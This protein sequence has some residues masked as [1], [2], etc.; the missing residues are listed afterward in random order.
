MANVGGAMHGHPMG[1]LSGGKAMRQAI[2][3]QF[4]NPEYIKAIEK[5]G[6]K[7]FSPDLAYRI[8]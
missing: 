4:D 3:K 5:W 8:F 7:E 6:H 2:D 1:T